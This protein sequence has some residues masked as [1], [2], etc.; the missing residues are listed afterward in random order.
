MAKQ[1]FSNFQKVCEFN[2]CFGLA[3][4]DNPQNNILE[5][6][7][8]LSKLR[9]DLCKEEIE[10]LNEAFDQKN[11]IEVID[12]LTDELYVL[13]GA[14]SSFGVDLDFEFRNRIKNLYFLKNI[15]KNKT[16]YQL[17]KMYIEQEPKTDHS[18]NNINK[19]LFN[20]DIPDKILNLKR[21]VNNDVSDLEIFKNLNNFTQVTR[22]LVYLLF[23]IYKLGMYLGIDL[24]KSF[25]IVHSSNM[26]KLCVDEVEAQL[27][28]DN[29]KK[30]Q[31]KYDSPNFKKS[32]N[33]NYWIVYNES[34]G[35]IL[36]SI[37]Y[38]PANFN[39]MLN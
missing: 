37:N 2:K 31:T 27:T 24:D 18:L 39:S 10:E 9:I 36:K 32:E 23:N 22:T 6:N 33:G 11:F 30:T 12:A 35:K 15:P 25:D 13:Y 1:K 17:L 5:E 28:V 19:T 8:N 21:V 29:Y 16:N 26:S 34:T 3:H 38:T 14:G 20:S 4:F 7:K